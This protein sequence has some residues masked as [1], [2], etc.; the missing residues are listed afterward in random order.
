[1][2]GCLL[3]LT[4]AVLALPLTKDQ[5]S[6]L[7]QFPKTSNTAKYTN[8]NPAKRRQKVL[9]LKV[10]LKSH[11][12]SNPTIIPQLVRASFHDL[13]NFGGSGS[14]PGAQGCLIDDPT[15][16]RFEQNK[17]LEKSIALV[18]LVKSKFP[19]FFTTA[20]IISLAGK[21]AVESSFPC[22]RIRW[23]YGRRS[24][25]LNTET[26]QGPQA[27]MTNAQELQ[28]FLTRYNLTAIEMAILTSGAHSIKDS[29]NHQVDTG[30]SQFTLSRINSGK[31]FL[32]N[33]FN[34]TWHFFDLGGKL[35][36]YAAQESH[37]TGRFPSD[38]MF[39]P[40]VL[41]TVNGSP[42]DSTFEPVEESLR[43]LANQP[44][45][46]FTNKFGEV[47]AKMLEIG[48]RDLKHFSYG[49]KCPVI[50]S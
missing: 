2:R 18:G 28:P 21:L 11:I 29:A 45:N 9:N 15:V 5:Q 31:Q 3:L 4:A 33:I 38:M 23:S 20:D 47:Y 24:C 34:S 13:L 32:L 30:I 49:R 14:D 41:K 7:H 46:V 43:A 16:S 36:W 27:S 44:E 19:G 39:F 42:V 26:E 35:N 48:T 37:N 40:S 25:R 8:R 12:A 1:M 10:F 6:S 17:G 50:L 22:L